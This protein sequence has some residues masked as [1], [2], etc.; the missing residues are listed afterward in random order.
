MTSVEKQH[1][2]EGETFGFPYPGRWPRGSR[3]SLDDVRTSARRW[4]TW[5][6]AYFTLMA[7]L[8]LLVVLAL[9][10]AGVYVFWRP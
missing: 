8:L 5:K 2:V 1:V 9:G 6:V 3:G 4:P 7:V 10:W